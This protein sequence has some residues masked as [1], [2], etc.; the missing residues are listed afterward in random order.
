MSNP[1]PLPPPG[2]DDLPV[3]EQIE[4]VQARPLAHSS[5]S[6]RLLTSCIVGRGADSGRRGKTGTP[7]RTFGPSWSMSGFVRT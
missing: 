1:V 4:Y 2:C 3:D 6:L 5:S 7:L